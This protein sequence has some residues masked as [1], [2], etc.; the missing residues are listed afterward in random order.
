M[1]IETRVNNAWEFV[2][3]SAYFKSC[4]ETDCYQSHRFH[5]RVRP[6]EDD[7]YQTRTIAITCASDSVA[8]LHDD[9]RRR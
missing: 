9:G 7:R 6:R 1:E 4:T 8:F 2:D 3:A 5:V